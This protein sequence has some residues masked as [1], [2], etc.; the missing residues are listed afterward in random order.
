MKESNIAPLDGI[1]LRVLRFFISVSIFILCV[2]FWADCGASAP[3]LVGA[4]LHE[5]AR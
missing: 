1:P 5:V 3:Q 4:A 2:F